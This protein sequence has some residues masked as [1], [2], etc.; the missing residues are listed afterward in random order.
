MAVAGLGA[1]EPGTVEVRFRPE[2]GDEFRFRSEVSTTA[3]RVVD[4]RAETTTER[5]VLDA[6]ETVTGID[7]GVVAVSVTVARDGGTPRTFEVTL[8]R[9]ARLADVDLVEGVPVEALGLELGADLPPGVGSPPPGPLA[10]GTRWIVEEPLDVPGGDP[11]VVRGRGEVVGLGVE[12][13]VEV[14]VAEVVLEVPVR[15]TVEADE[16][17]VTL[18]GTQTSRA[19]TAYDL[20][21]G[22]LHRETTVVTGV[23][24]LLVAP[25]PGIGAAPVRG[26][27]DYRIEAR[28]LR[29]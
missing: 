26:T 4:G 7:D 13:G 29:R 24:D 28:T 17:S 22:A 6:T 23:V 8:D 10:P 18:V 21:D 15:A 2:V 27:L 19:E 20:S 14:A 5:A 12:D 25:P 16:G 3:T 9:S 1:C 11:V